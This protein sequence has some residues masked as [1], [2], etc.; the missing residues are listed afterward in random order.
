MT[1]SGIFSISILPSTM[2]AYATLEP[3]LAVTG[4]FI[5]GGILDELDFFGRQ[6]VEHIHQLIDLRSQAEADDAF[7]LEREV[8]VYS[9]AIF[10]A[11]SSS[12]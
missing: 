5:L 9:R 3:F 11:T 1:G 6:A 4:G 2:A 8:R 7:G 12:D 10:I